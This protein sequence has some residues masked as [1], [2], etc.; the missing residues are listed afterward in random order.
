MERKAF[1]QSLIGIAGLTAF[2]KVEFST[3]EKVYL[4]QCFI[5]GFQYYEGPEIIEE[6]NKIGQ[7]ELVREPE[8]PY[9]SN[10]IAIYFEG[11]KLGFIPREENTILS[12]LMDA[13]LLS[14]H[15]EITHIEP[16]AMD[17]EKVFVAVYALKEI[18]NQ[19]DLQKISPFT[20]LETSEYYS[21]LTKNNE[22]I[23]I[24][25]S[26]YE[27]HEDELI[28]EYGEIDDDF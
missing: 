23:R 8:N 2:S 6:I 4:L 20:T 24:N 11:K 19:Q 27:Q 13:E 25:R 22:I 12:T 14:F 10:A 16:E 28:A 18:K 1:L 15:I 26:D 3:Y 5:R 21:V 9:D 7:V 17:W